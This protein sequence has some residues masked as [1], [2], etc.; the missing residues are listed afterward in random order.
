M[1]KNKKSNA[2]D[3]MLK[4]QNI[5]YNSN[6]KKTQKTTASER[7]TLNLVMMTGSRMAKGGQAQ[8]TETVDQYNCVSI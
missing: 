1:K 5:V 6:K 8:Y 3:V 7:A 4:I 2:G